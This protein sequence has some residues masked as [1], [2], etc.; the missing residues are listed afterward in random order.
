[1]TR[2]ID[3]AMAAIRPAKQTIRAKWLDVCQQWRLQ[4]RHEPL[5][6]T[7]PGSD[8]YDI[9]MLIEAGLIP[10]LENRAIADGAA[11][12][13]V[14]VER[15]VM[16]A[17]RLRQKFPGLKVVP[18]DIG[19]ELRIAK[20]IADLSK[21]AKQYGRGLVINLDFNQPL[22]VQ[23]NQYP[24]LELV[25]RLGDLHRHPSPQDWTLLLTLNADPGAWPHDVCSRHAR[26]LIEVM[27]TEH[28]LD[29]WWQKHGEELGPI[30]DGS[31]SFSDWSD[32]QQQCMLL[33][34]MP[35]LLLGRLAATGWDVAVRWA[36]VYGER[37]SGHAP[38]VTWVVDI[39]YDP[40]ACAQ[41]VA[42]RRKLVQVLLDAVGQVDTDGSWSSLG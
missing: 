13:V 41:P 21:E 19:E 36:A 39:N 14:A 9:S 29:A 28:G 18:K 40:D 38:M 12:L 31:K 15:D 8:G 10:I 35:L 25:G 6:V 16:A 42:Q 23:N 26:T 17:S 30:G 34:L 3:S 11:G 32:D 27:S 24:V 37:G 1:M 20:P 5:Y 4:S 22:I 7:L 2:P 33:T